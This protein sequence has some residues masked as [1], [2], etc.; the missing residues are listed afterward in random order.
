[1]NIITINNGVILMADPEGFISGGTVDINGKVYE[2]VIPRRYNGELPEDLAPEKY[3]L[4]G[5]EIVLN[6]DFFPNDIET[7]LN[8][9]EQI[10][11]EL[12]DTM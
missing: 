1:M 9:I 4:S 8:D 5:N 6:P 11:I 3:M 12:L 10:L 2:N 7:R